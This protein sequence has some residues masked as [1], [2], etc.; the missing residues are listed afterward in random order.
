MRIDNFGVV[1]APDE[2]ADAAVDLAQ[3]LLAVDV[4]TVLG[5]I[6]VARGPGDRGDDFRTL[7]VDERSQL[8]LQAGET[9]G[10]HVVA[11]TRRKRWSR[12]E[13]LVEVRGVRLAR[14]GFA[15]ERSTAVERNRSRSAACP[16][17]L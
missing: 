6:T 2:K 10:C 16:P 1:Q 7:L 4:I 5:A 11:T 13:L 3:A 14:K 17:E 9:A 15:H 12:L 8:R